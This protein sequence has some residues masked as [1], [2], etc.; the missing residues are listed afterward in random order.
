VAI[1]NN[2]VILCKV[3]DKKKEKGNDKMAPHTRTRTGKSKKKKKIAAM[4]DV[5]DDNYNDNDTEGEKDTKRQRTDDVVPPEPVASATGTAVSANNRDSDDDKLPSS[6]E[7]SEELCNIISTRYSRDEAL[8]TLE[9]LSKWAF[10]HD[11]D[12]LK[13]FH[14]Y[15]GVVKVLDF[16]KKTMKDGNC[17]GAVRM[18]CIKK[19]AN[20]IANV[21]HHGGNNENVDI[22]TKIATTLMECDGINT[23]INAS[24][25][26]AGGDDVPQLKALSSVW[27]ALRNITVK[28]DA[29]SKDQ[30]IAIFDTGIDIISQLKSI[31]IP[32][33]SSALEPVFYTLHNIVYFNY[34]TKKYFQDKKIISNCLAVFK[35]DNT[36]TCR[37]ETLIR[38]VI[39]FFQTCRLK[40]FLDKSSDYEMLLPLLVMALK[41]YPSN[42]DI[43]KC[44][45]SLL[46]GACS[47]VNDKNTI[48]RSGAME[49]LGAL[50]TSDDIN[51]DGKNQ[52]RI[53]IH[54]ISAP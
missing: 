20:V 28:K 23:L 34:V 8:R 42:D 10:T 54:N 46:Y 18:E 3:Q 4:D 33:A 31:D 52:V 12:F 43:R 47:T 11:S 9:R 51:E 25:E 38:L 5:D 49:V 27:M 16:L 44:V 17:I 45:L 14:R 37:N 24:E 22:A 6:D 39:G 29:I 32:L 40:N 13:S 21:T 15:S 41:E 50:F 35:K 7:L 36:W 2:T 53:L 1:E 48:V 19:A 30:A 26:Y